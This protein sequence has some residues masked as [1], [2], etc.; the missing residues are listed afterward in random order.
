[1][2]ARGDALLANVLG[3]IHH[4]MG[5]LW[6]AIVF[7]LLQDYLSAIIENW[8]LLFAPIVIVL[9]LFSPQGLHGLGQRLFSHQRYTLVRDGLPERPKQIAPFDAA[10]E[11]A[12][13]STP[14][15]EIRKLSRHFGAW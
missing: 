13:T 15:L 9:A 3:G 1:L 11:T 6:G 5:P 12:D 4:F 10:G 8:W 2:A 14:V 7:I